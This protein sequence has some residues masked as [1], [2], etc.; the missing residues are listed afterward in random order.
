MEPP[1]LKFPSYNGTFGDIKGIMNLKPAGDDYTTNPSNIVDW[2]I[3]KKEIKQNTRKRT[4]KD[5]E[6]REL[7][8]RGCYFR[9]DLY[10][11]YRKMALFQEKKI[12]ELVNE[13]LEKYLKESKKTEFQKL[14]D[15]GQAQLM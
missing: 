10:K 1:I 13:A 9:K 12:Y 2:N 14:I 4:F 11:E 8:S 5:K 15:S 7:E 6:G 3:G